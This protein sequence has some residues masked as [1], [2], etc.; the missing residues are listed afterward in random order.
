MVIVGRDQFPDVH[1]S[2]GTVEPLWCACQPD[3]GVKQDLHRRHWLA[4]RPGQDR[5]VR[6]RMADD[7]RL[8]KRYEKIG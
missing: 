8:A 1:L 7:V 5:R 3:P 2:G 6:W 4:V